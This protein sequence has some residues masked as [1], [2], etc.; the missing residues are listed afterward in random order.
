MGGYNSFY[1]L[2]LG[3][4]PRNGERGGISRPEGENT[5]YH[6]SLH[7]RNGGTYYIRLKD[8]DAV[9][10]WLRQFAGELHSIFI[11]RED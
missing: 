1:C 10:A 3:K 6:I 9:I 8:W 7:R 2:Q 4:M 5:M 11:V